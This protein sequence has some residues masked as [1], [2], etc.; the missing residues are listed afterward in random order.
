MGMLRHF[1]VLEGAGILQSLEI[2]RFVSYMFLHGSLLHLLLNM[3]W[4]YYLSKEAKNFLSDSQLFLVYMVSGI[5]GGVFAILF[6]GGSPVVGSSG[7]VFGLLGGLLAYGRKRKDIVGFIVW[8]KFS[9]LAFMMILLGFLLPGVSNSGHI[10]GIAGGFGISWLLLS[11]QKM[12]FFFLALY[13]VL[14][15][16]LLWA[17]LNMLQILP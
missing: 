10:G 9:F 17:L 15:F 12:K 1:R 5:S 4:F 2:F 11:T 7:A 6:G 16:L 14:F 13:I 8:K 3:F